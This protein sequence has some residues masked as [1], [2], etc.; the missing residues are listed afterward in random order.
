MED[1][2]PTNRIPPPV[3]TTTIIIVVTIPTSASLRV[4]VKG[5]MEI[6]VITTKEELG[7]IGTEEGIETV[8]EER[9]KKTLLLL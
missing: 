5:G 3:V 9:R 6:E 8:T 1:P 4:G 7:N 2:P